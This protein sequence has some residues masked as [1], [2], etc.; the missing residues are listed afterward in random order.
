MCPP[1]GPDAGN[2][3]ARLRR[4]AIFTPGKTHCG[5]ESRIEHR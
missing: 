2:Y 1:G 3:A 5:K 4:A